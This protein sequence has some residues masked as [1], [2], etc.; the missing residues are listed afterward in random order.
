LATVLLCII[1]LEMTMKNSNST[2]LIWSFILLVATT[3][4]FCQTDSHQ[5]PPPPPF[6]GQAPNLPDVAKNVV[7]GQLKKVEKTELTIAKPDGVEQRVAVDANTKFVGDHG[8]A[9]T[10]ADFK[11][12]DQV[13]AIGTLKDGVFVAA[14]L[15]KVPSGPGAPPP[16]PT[17]PNQGSN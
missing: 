1:E 15:A 13:A 16:P 7:L 11:P 10:L 5:G 12:G 4:A 14:Q 2:Y 3:S 9:I 17:A 6:G 8:A